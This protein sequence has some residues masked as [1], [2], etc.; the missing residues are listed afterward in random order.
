MLLKIIQMSNGWEIWCTAVNG[1]FG[2]V[3]WTSV[4]FWW[5]NTPV[6][7][8]S[9]ELFSVTFLRSDAKDCIFCRLSS[10][11]IL[12]ALHTAAPVTFQDDGYFNGAIEQV[13]AIAF[14]M[15]L[16]PH[17]NS[18]KHLQNNWYAWQIVRYTRD[19]VCQ[20]C[21]WSIVEYWYHSSK[22]FTNLKTFS[23]SRDVSLWH[24]T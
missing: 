23:Q 10:I 22:R 9:L 8:I 2:K 18:Y 20:V 7:N 3:S 19:K 17:I 1:S 4:F 12:L 5:N 15:K 14:K 6:L 16:W 13:A 21:L 24:G 11:M